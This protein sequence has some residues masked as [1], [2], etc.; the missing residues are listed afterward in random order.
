MEAVPRLVAKPAPGSPPAAPRPGG[1]RAPR[2]A[3]P[4]APRP[5]RQP[6]AKRPNPG[7]AGAEEEGE[8]GTGSRCGT[9]EF[10]EEKGCRG[11]TGGK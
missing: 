10:N 4:G 11:Q 3:R 7:E 9:A 1:A 5:G 8:V 6:P 2:A